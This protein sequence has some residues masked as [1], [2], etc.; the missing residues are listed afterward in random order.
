M[1]ANQLLVGRYC[2]ARTDRFV[3]HCGEVVFIDGDKV[4]LRNSKRFTQTTVSDESRFLNLIS[5]DGVIPQH[6][7]IDET[8]PEIYLTYVLELIPCSAKAIEIIQKA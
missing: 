8:I 1:S 5:K 7:D 3:I 4:F 6:Y 2:I